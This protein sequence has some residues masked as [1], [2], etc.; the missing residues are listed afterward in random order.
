MDRVDGIEGLYICTG[1]SGHGF[2]LAPA[3]GV[4]MSELVLDGE[5][6]LVDITPLRMGRFSDGSLNTTQYN[7]KVIA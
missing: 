7:F 2:K 5:S 4:C 6:K 3:V 1:F